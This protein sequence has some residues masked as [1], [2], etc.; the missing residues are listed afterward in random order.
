MREQI[1]KK[2]IPIVII[3]ILVLTGLGA[4]AF[5]TNISFEK[6]TRTTIEQTTS[7]AFSTPFIVQNTDGFSEI[8]L[9]EATTMLIKPNH[10]ILPISVTVYEI[11]FRSENIQITCTIQDTHTQNLQQ[12]IIPARIAPQSRISQEKSY[13]MDETIYSSQELYP[14]TWYTT[15]ITS[16][17]NENNIVVTYVKV[18]TYPVRYSPANNEITYT[19][20]FDIQL[21]Y[22]TP[23]AQT[24]TYEDEFDMV[25]IGPEEFQS[26]IQTLIDHKNSYNVQTMFKST[27]AIF[28]EYEGFDPPEQLKYFI[29]DAYDNWNIT[30]VLLAG[31]LQ[32]HL[33]AKDKDS[34]S[35]GYTAWHIPVRYVSIP[36][37]LEVGCLSDLYYGCI[38]NG[39]GDFDS[40][41]SNG[42]GIYAAWGIPG[43]PND[44]FD[45]NPEVYVSRLAVRNKMELRHV[46]KKLITYES[47]APEDKEWFDTFIGIG[48]KTF[49]YYQG[50]PDGEY[51]C[52]LAAEYLENRYT[53][54]N[55]VTVYSTNRD[56]GGYV[57]DKKGISQAMTQ[58]AGFVG[59]QG[60]GNP[61]SWNNIWHDGEY[62][63]DWIGGIM[64]Y[65]FWRIQNAKKL[66]V[67]IV[68][69]CHNGMYNVSIIPSMKDKE[70]VNYW[71]YGMPAPVCF[72]WGLI[73]KP[74]GGAI[75]ST[76]CTGYGVGSQGMPVSLSGELES[77]FYWQIGLNDAETLGQAHSHSIQKFILENNI[78]A[79][80]AFVITNWAL[81][82]D[83]SMPF[84]GYSS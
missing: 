80:E 44:E 20:G 56:T 19:K 78:A 84:G 15:Q 36:R 21:S 66:P 50:K 77:N 34:I 75:A 7:L 48:A 47:S 10:P 2:I 28:D 55:H 81:F 1:M 17:R 54:L 68:G 45:M 8:E 39:T 53:N 74:F 63:D 18:V 26:E 12:K 11:P 51:L 71:S 65:D 76:G 13:I 52:D 14:E 79:T 16:G 3:G 6:T 58:G 57:P 22:T 67:V 9:P 73:V 27:Q 24:T 41:D 30:Y 32:S 70:G 38:Y 31:G 49:D 69:G 23:Q 25:I 5:N 33:Y 60:H 4:A 64:I 35:A 62:P 46:I 43:M 72:S 40:W 59:F 61:V 37:S 29:K 42:D 83:P 82:G